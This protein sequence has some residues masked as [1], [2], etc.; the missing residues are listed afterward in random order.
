LHCG[1]KKIPVLKR[2]KNKLFSRL[3]CEIYLTTAAKSISKKFL[4]GLYEQ[5]ILS[6]NAGA[7][8]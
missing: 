3:K 6:A 1:V 5:P 4:G 2:R 8:Y 7:K